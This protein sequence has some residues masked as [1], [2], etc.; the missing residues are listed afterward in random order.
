M[1]EFYTPGQKQAIKVIL[2]E[3]STTGAPELYEDRGYLRRRIIVISPSLLETGI[4]E[5][6][7][8]ILAGLNK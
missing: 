4:K 5:V 3:I 6:V 1:S 8:Y 2:K 7:N